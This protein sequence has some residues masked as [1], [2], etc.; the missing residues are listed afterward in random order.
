MEL[1]EQLRNRL[2]RLA[3]QD[4][5]AL[6]EAARR[7]VR[8]AIYE[9]MQRR[10]VRFGWGLAP[11]MLVSSA[12]AWWVATPSHTVQPEGS[13]PSS[14]RSAAPAAVDT[15]RKAPEAVPEPTPPQVKLP[16]E[17]VQPR[18]KRA[19]VSREVVID[20]GEHD[21]GYEL[22]RQGELP[23]FQ[24]DPPEIPSSVQPDGRPMKKPHVVP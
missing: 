7:R 11:A 16:R 6:D 3:Q 9:R 23:A 12:F 22:W 17:R 21:A 15:A 10:R 19:F 14:P 2:Q 13:P 18:D 24:P 20:A 8:A 4:D 5:A 1:D